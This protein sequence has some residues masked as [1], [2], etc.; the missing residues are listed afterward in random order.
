MYRE[1]EGPPDISKELAKSPIITIVEE[2]DCFVPR[3]VIRIGYSGPN[4]R[5]IIRQAPRV[6]QRSLRISGTAVFID[7]YYVDVTDP[8][9]TSFHIFWHGEKRF[10][11]RSKMFGFF[12]VKQGILHPDGTGSMNIEFFSKLV[13]KWEKKTFIQRTPIYTLFRKIYTYI[14]YDDARRN[15]IERCKFHEEDMIRRAK[16]LLRLVETHPYPVG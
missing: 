13:T 12:R 1:E 3:R 2:Y 7:E 10:D 9:R 11:Q 6:I 4:I 15:F 16:E 14:Y 8:N 5:E